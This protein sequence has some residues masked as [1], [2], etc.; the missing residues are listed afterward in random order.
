MSFRGEYWLVVTL[1][2][3]SGRSPAWS[4]AAAKKRNALFMVEAWKWPE[5]LGEVYD[6][7]R[8]DRRQTRSARGCFPLSVEGAEEWPAANQPGSDGSRCRSEPRGRPANGE[9]G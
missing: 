9:T 3:N 7:G 8:R 6:E 4:A 5:K 2:K 1:S